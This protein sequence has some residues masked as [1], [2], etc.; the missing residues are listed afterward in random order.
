MDT[1]KATR[2]AKGQGMKMRD[3]DHPR[4]PHSQPGKPPANAPKGTQ[5]R[6]R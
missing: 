2:P 1:K 5:E 6:L 3:A 4:G